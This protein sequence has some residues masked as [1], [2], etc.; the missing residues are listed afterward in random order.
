LAIS[1]V[2]ERRRSFRES[3]LLFLTGKL[4]R[5]TKVFIRL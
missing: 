2:F 5:K 1:S 3:S 4:D